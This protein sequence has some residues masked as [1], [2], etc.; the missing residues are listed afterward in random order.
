MV[1]DMQ[2]EE[3]TIITVHDASEVI[4]ELLAQ[5]GAVGLAV[6]DK[7][8]IRLILEDPNSLSYADEGFLDSQDDEVTVRAYFPIHNDVVLIRNAEED[9]DL[10]FDSRLY[11]YNSGVSLNPDSLMNRMVKR[12]SKISEFLPVGALSISHTTVHQEDWENNWKKDYKRFNLS[13]R[14]AV[15]PTWEKSDSS[16]ASDMI[17]IYLDPGS[18]FG[19][20][21]H[22]T[23]MMCA[24]L[25]DRLITRDDQVLDLGCG[26]GIL[27]IVASKLGASYVEAIDI[28][29]QAVAVA[30]QNIHDN[31]VQVFCHSGELK[32]ASQNAY[33]L[34]VANIIADVLVDLSTQIGS[35]LEESGRIIVSGIIASKRQA[36]VNAFIANDFDIFDETD[37]NDWHAI[38]FVRKTT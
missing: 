31:G 28:D 19:T 21:T 18:A 38:V 4:C 22:E 16:D 7:E 36:V 26:S 30:E 20:G 17:E 13:E 37:L 9:F 25:L 15:C 29:S 10:S 5:W 11:D 32:D 8:D 34:V 12:F 3:Y 35:Y 14:I 33:S 2:W 6:T 24:R 23:T 1:F 27:S